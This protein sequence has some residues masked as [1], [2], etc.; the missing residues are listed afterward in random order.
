MP[1]TA[2]V[3]LPTTPAEVAAAA[4]DGIQNDPSAFEM[5]NWAWLTLSRQLTPD[6]AP[7]CGTTLCAAGWVAHVTG[8]TIVDLREGEQEVRATSPR[9][10][11]YLTHAQVYAE[12][13]GDRRLICDVAREALGLKEPETFWYGDADTAIYRLHDIA[14]R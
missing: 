3:R 13:D 5:G 11:E 4:L 12:K 7:A 10:G 6:Q 14:G 2:H 8:W 9:G 1:A